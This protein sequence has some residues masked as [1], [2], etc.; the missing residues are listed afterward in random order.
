MR[1]IVELLQRL[2]LGRVELPQIECPSLTQEN[3]A[4]ERDL[5]HVDELD[6]LAHHV[7]DAGLEAGQLT[8]NPRT[9]PSLSRK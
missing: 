4:E 5:D 6:F 2:V 1:R 7:P 9:G 3:P 8:K